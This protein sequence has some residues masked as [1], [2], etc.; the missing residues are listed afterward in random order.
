MKAS[1]LLILVLFATRVTAWSQ[2]SINNYKYVLVPEK[3]DAFKTNNQY[4]LNA[5]AKLLLTEKGFTA[6]MGNEEFPPEVASNRCNALRTEVATNNGLFV[7]KLTLF[8]KDC[9]GN[10]IFKSKEGK[11]REKDFQAAYNEAFNDA[12]S[13]LYNEPYK[14]DG[15]TF[16]PT[17]QA[18]VTPAASSSAPAQAPAQAPASTPATTASTASEATGILYAQATPNGFQ[19]IDT[20]PKKVLTLLKTSQQD[21]FIGEAGSSNGIVFKKNEEWFF[22]YYKDNKLVSQKLQIKF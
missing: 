11:S 1:A 4:G 5:L 21:Y 2:N 17:Q 18:T 3:F 22:E 13:S 14:Y 9:Q 16:T 20:T 19:L 6:F 12:F 7:T 10:I 8:L 15:T